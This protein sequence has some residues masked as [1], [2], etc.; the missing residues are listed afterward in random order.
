MTQQAE[1]ALLGLEWGCAPTV[2]PW[3][4]GWGYFT[5]FSILQGREAELLQSTRRPAWHRHRTRR[6]TSSQLRALL[7]GWMD[8]KAPFGRGTNR[9]QVEGLK[10]QAIAT[11]A[12]APGDAD[13]PVHAEGR[14]GFRTR[15]DA[16]DVGCMAACERA[17]VGARA[18]HA[19]DDCRTMCVLAC[20]ESDPATG[21]FSCVRQRQES[22]DDSS[23]SAASP[24]AHHQP[25]TAYR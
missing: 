8:D 9:A 16:C 2:L 24:S 19:V 5:S 4:G 1:D 12:E 3:V 17:A 13:G 11:S 22:P 25:D 14:S 21:K 10:R 23:P 6:S 7:C 20:N 18:P 15:A